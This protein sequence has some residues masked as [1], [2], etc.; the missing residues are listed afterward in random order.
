MALLSDSSIGFY[1]SGGPTNLSPRESY[2]GEKSA[3][4]IPA[5]TKLFKD[6][7][8]PEKETGKTDYRII[9]VAID[10]DEVGTGSAGKLWLTTT[11]LAAV[12]YE[13]SVGALNTI[14]EKPAS[15][16]IAPEGL[17]F[18]PSATT[19]VAGLALPDLEGGDF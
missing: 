13:L 16:I 11:D 2:G 1:F 12:T 4:L 5:G 19:E 17:T 18:T 9:Y 3:N 15:E 10:D 6:I 14:I 7:Q 8:P